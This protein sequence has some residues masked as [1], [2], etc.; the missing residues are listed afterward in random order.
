MIESERSEKDF[1]NTTDDEMMAR[2]KKSLQ[3]V[4]EG[5]TRNIHEFKKDIVSWKENR[6]IQ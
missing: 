4:E 1:Y 3:S 6:A 2:A 5:N